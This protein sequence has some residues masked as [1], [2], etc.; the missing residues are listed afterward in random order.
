MFT[1]KTLKINLDADDPTQAL[2]H[3]ETSAVL[4]AKSI[5]TIVAGDYMDYVIRPATF[6]GTSSVVNSGSV[7]LSVGI[8]HYQYGTMAR[9]GYFF[10]SQSYGWTGSINTNTASLTNVI[11]TLATDAF[12]AQFEVILTRTT[13]PSSGS[14]TTI[15]QS[16]I[17]IRQQVLR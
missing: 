3:D 5:G 14:Q 1:P 8:G 12:P 2:V 15:L 17:T 7:R 10:T 4:N 11:D 16:D 6:S 13:G 9:S